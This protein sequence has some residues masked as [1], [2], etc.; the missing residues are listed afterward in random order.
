MSCRMRRPDRIGFGSSND[1]ISIIIHNVL[2][3]FGVF[4]R[5]CAVAFLDINSIFINLATALDA[6][7]LRSQFG[8]P[9]VGFAKKHS[10]ERKF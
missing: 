8:E 5:I 10:F 4:P 9:F 2:D 1:E 6:G 3:L 7:S